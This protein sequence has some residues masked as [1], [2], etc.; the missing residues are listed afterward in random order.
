MSQTISDILSSQNLTRAQAVAGVFTTAQATINSSANRGNRAAVAGSLI[1]T[2][3]GILNSF[4]ATKQRT[5]EG[6]NVSDFVSI[7][8]K[9]GGFV[10]PSHFLVYIT[11]P[12]WVIQQAEKS[13][14]SNFNNILPFLCYRA[15]LPGV[16]FGSV[17][18]A[19][20]GYSTPQKRPTSPIFEDVTLEFYMDNTGVALDFFTKWLQNIINYDPDAIGSKSKSGAF[21]NEVSYMEN[22]T[23]QVDIYLFDATAAEVL[24]VKLHEAFPLSVGRVNLDWRGQN[25]IAT[26]PIAMTFRTWSSNFFTPATIDNNSLRN[27][28]LGDAL[29]RIGSG[30]TTLSSL[31]RRPTGIADV[32][33]TVRTASSVVRSITGL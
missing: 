13:Q 22:Y 21:Y 25:S 31:V 29:I 2:V 27:L 14:A 7:A 24:H 12:K 8:S 16:V 6:F 23:T 26:L 10:N 1:S 33:N 5:T 19:H 18:V 17:P 28:S 20:F 3:G 4:N 32:F 15:Q 30:V 11:P 9:L